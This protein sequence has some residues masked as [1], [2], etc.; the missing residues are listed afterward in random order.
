MA[1]EITKDQLETI[2]NERVVNQ[3]EHFYSE[4]KAA[5]ENYVKSLTSNIF[6]DHQ[7]D[8]YNS[9]IMPNT[10]EPETTKRIHVKKLD[11]NKWAS[12]LDW[13]DSKNEILF[14]KERY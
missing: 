14:S 4:N 12:T 11:R 6:H 3:K 1:P 10:K 13:K 7:K 8:K 5:R 2:P 9:H